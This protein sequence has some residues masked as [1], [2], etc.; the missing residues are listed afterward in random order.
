MP[1]VQYVESKI[2]EKV[3]GK[4]QVV[5]PREYAYKAGW[6]AQQQLT[7]RVP[8]KG[9]ILL[10]AYTPELKPKKLTYEEFRDAISFRL[11]SAPKGLT[12]S[13]VRVMDPRLPVKPPAIWVGRLEADIGLTR[14]PDPGTGYRIWKLGSQRVTAMK[15]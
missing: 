6:K 4:F 14:I 1:Q 10:T 9:R 7:F 5:V 8:G 13:Q 15:A 3:Y 2:G 12:Y 11:R